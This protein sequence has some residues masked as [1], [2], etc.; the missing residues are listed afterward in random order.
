[1]NRLVTLSI[2]A[3]LLVPA[4]VR[5]GEP[6]DRKIISAIRAE[7]FGNSQIMDNIFWMSEVHGPRLTGSPGLDDASEW[8]RDKLE[9][10]GLK[11]A[12]IEEWGTF[13]RGW[14]LDGFSVEMTVPHYLR[15]IAFPKAWTPGTDGTVT[16]QP[17]LVQADTVEDLEKYMGKLKGKIVLTQAERDAGPT[18]EPDA[19]RF[20]GDE[21]A[22]RVKARGGRRRGGRNFDRAAFRRQRAVRNR[23]RA[24]FREE[25]VAAM[26]EPSRGQHGTLFVGSGGSSAADADPVPPSLV[27]AVEHYNQIVRLIKHDVDVDLKIS[28]KARFLDERPG[29]NIVAEIPGHDPDLKDEL[30]MLGGHFDAWHSSNGVTDNAASCAVAMEV[31]R[32]L[33]AIG[34]KNRRTIRIALWTGEEQGLRGSRAYVTKH[35]ADRS[36]MDLKPDHDKLSAYFNLDNGGGRIRGIYCQGNE[37]VRP[38]FTAWLEPFGDLDARTVTIRNTGGTDHQSFDGVGLPGFQ[39]IQDPIEYDTRTHHTNMDTI[40]RVVEEDVMQ[41]A[42]IMASF[43]YHAANRDEKLPREPLP[44]PRSRR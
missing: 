34:A 35:F 21:L 5:A 42:V 37:A 1:M 2:L 6:V 38:I 33:K 15:L 22:D 11:N 4:A 17:V 13:G 40:E 36:T 10:W 14:V 3:C 30:V 41:A 9:E 27:V 28:V 44:K 18:F 16:G 8:C 31:C 19:Q 12:K 26:L 25:G 39:F 7:G 29:A 23:M 43:V 20:T 24:M 32:I